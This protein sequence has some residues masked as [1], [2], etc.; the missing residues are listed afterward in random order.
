MIVIYGTL[1][2]NHDISRYFFHFFKI[3]ISWVVKGVKGQKWPKM[4]KNSVVFHISG[5]I[6]HMI[7][8]NDDISRYVFHFFKILILWV[9]KGVKGQKLV[10][11]KKKFCLSCSISQEPYIIWFLFMVHMC[12]MMCTG[13]FFSFS[14]FWSFQ[15]VR[16]V[17]GQKIVQNDKKFYLSHPISHE[18]YIIWSSFAVC[19]FKVFMRF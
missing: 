10:Q 2:W 3:L 4:T 5:I 7:V 1:V 8:W 15:I 19:K 16:V 12:K 17:K 6:H 9:V 11:S 13:I 14:K 18:P